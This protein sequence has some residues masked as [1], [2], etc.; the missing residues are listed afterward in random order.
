MRA[1]RTIAIMGNGPL[2]HMPPLKPYQDEVDIWIGA[3]RGAL[4]LIE[5]GIQ[6]D[7]AVGDFDS[8]DEKQMVIIKNHSHHVHTHPAEKNETDLEIALLKA[9]ES[10]PD[11]IYFFGVTG[12]RMDHTLSNIQLLHTMVDKQIRGIIVDK[13]NQ[14][15]MMK[16]GSYAV[17]KSE[18]YPY[19]SFIPVT[20]HVKSLSLTGFQYP[21]LDHDISWGQTR[22][23]SNSLLENEGAFTFKSG[24]LIMIK[25]RDT[26]TNTV[27]L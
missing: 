12:G 17:Y 19:I 3:D 4:T 23:I 10:N 5:S 27:P 26:R 6:V 8:I 18:Q 22:C 14:L 1:V 20:Q 7:D 25:S 21:L 9:L 13:W 24:R 11:I 2:D 15:E 16:P